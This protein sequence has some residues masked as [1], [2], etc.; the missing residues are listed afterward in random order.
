M[1]ILTDVQHDVST[2]NTDVSA[3]D[4]PNICA[5]GHQGQLTRSQAA[6]VATKRMT[7]RRAKQR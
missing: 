7:G 1:H 2:C 5:A 6:T 4:D 3:L